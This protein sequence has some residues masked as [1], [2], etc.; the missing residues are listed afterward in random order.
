MNV[1]ELGKQGDS[2]AKDIVGD[3]GYEME[4][5]LKEKSGVAVKARFEGEEWKKCKV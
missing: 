3:M 1:G 4:A 5:A 2:E